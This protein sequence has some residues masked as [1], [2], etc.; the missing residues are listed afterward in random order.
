MEISYAW[1]NTQTH[2]ATQWHHCLKGGTDG[3]LPYFLCWFWSF[4]KT[5]LQWCKTELSPQCWPPSAAAAAPFPAV[6]LEALM[7]YH[8]SLVGEEMQEDGSAVFSP[9]AHGLKPVTVHV[10]CVTWEVLTEICEIMDRIVIQ[11]LYILVLTSCSMCNLV[12]E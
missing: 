6:A 5:H 3:S 11:F 7:Q 2:A 9:H 12:A 10:C 4:L 8:L 1:Q